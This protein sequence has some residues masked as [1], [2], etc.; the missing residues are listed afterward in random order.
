[1]LTRC[2]WSSWVC[3]QPQSRYRKGQKAGSAQRPVERSCA[4]AEPGRWSGRTCGPSA[5]VRAAAAAAALAARCWRR[6]A[7]PAC[8]AERPPLSV[9]TRRWRSAASPASSPSARAAAA[10]RAAGSR[11]R[12]GPRA[13]P[14]RSGGRGAYWTCGGC[15]R[16]RLAATSAQGE[17]WAW[18]LAGSGSS[19]QGAG[20]ARRRTCSQPVLSSRRRPPTASRTQAPLAPESTPWPQALYH[21][22]APHPA[23]C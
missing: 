17:C 12:T 8:A 20:T 15:K 10:R 9:S 19:S 7:A 13:G 5:R 1:M 6:R 14:R 21:A 18:R 11:R 2:R 4:S 3:E 23:V 16:R 22:N